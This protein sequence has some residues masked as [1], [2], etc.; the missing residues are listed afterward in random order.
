MVEWEKLACYWLDGMDRP[1]VPDGMRWDEGTNGSGMQI[2]SV[3]IG[4]YGAE[5]NGKRQL[6]PLLLVLQEV[7]NICGSASNNSV[8]GCRKITNQLLVMVFT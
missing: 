3:N 4:S 2:G 7:Q 5:G 8:E 6:T 1:E